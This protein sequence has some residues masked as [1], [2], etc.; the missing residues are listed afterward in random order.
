LRNKLFPLNRHTFKWVTRFVR[1]K[2]KPVIASAVGGIP[3]QIKHNITGILVHSIE[4]AAMAIKRLLKN[5]ELAKKLGENG[6]RFVKQNFLITRHLKDY[7]MLILL[8]LTGKSGV[9][10]I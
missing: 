1:W 6:R 3:L 4:G 10:E 7:L 8:V 5:S 9:M 2:G